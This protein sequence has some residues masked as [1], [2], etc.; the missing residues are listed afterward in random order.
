VSALRIARPGYVTTL[1]DLGPAVGRVS[2][3][4]GPTAGMRSGV[5]VVAQSE[6][7]RLR[8]QQRRYRYEVSRTERPASER[9][10]E[11]LR[12]VEKHNGSRAA[13]S[14]ELGVSESAVSRCLRRLVAKGYIVPEATQ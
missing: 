2:F 6:A 8:D 14:R 1:I 10:H 4:R 5:L 7:T 11:V 12:I 9:A 3:T 13:A